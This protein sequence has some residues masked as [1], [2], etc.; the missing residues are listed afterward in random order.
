MAPSTVSCVPTQTRHEGLPARRTLGLRPDPPQGRRGRSPQHGDR[1]DPSCSAE[2]SEPACER[3]LG[4]W[5]IVDP[6][7]RA[8]GV[9]S[10]ARVV[11]ALTAALVVSI[12]LPVGTAEANES[13][14]DLAKKT[15]NPVADLISVPFQNNFS[16]GAGT[17]DD[18]VWVM[19][20]Q[21]VIPVSLNDDWNVITRTIL[22][23]VNQPSLLPGMDAAFGMGDL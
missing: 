22:P 16:F 11:A 3:D 2:I 12:A 19:N 17:D 15:Q 7:R 23:I 9:F 13:E 20:V 6:N 8:D 5:R 10:R 4:A 14:T 1:F 18:V 21:P